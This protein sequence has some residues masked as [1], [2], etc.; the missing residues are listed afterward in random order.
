MYGKSLLDKGRR[1][2]GDVEKDTVIAVDLHLVI[3]GTGDDVTRGQILE[4][5]VASHEGMTV[6]PAQNRPLATHR[7]GNQE[8]FGVRVIQGGGVKLHELHVGNG[9]PG[10]IGHGDPVTGSDIGIAGI[11]IDL[12]GAPGRQHGNR[13]AEGLDRAAGDVEYVGA[14][15]VVGSDPPPLHLGFGDQIDGDVPFVKTNV[16]VSED[17]LHQGPL[18]LLAGFV[19]GVVDAPLA[20]APLAGQVVITGFSPGETYAEGDQFGD[21]RRTVLYHQ[22]DDRLVGEP[23][24]GFHGV[25]NMLGKG[26]VSRGNRGDAALRQAGGGGG[27]VALGDQGNLAMVGNLQGVGKTGNAAADHQKIT[28]EFHRAP[29][30]EICKRYQGDQSFCIIISRV[31]TVSSG[32]IALNQLKYRCFLVI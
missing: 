26:I 23:G 24:S 4:V 6:A 18:D 10:T 3:N 15:T 20:V 16:G 13:C 27:D 17:R 30:N 29:W 28:D 11:E 1:L 22:A 32:L 31:W 21:C 19:F 7:L 2:V 25:A 14:E 12:A 5:M 9:R 8:A